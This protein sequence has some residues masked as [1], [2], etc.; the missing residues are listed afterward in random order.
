M[1]PRSINLTNMARIKRSNRASLSPIDTAPH[2]PNSARKKPKPCLMSADEA[3]CSK[4]CS[5]SYTD[6][7]RVDV[8]V[9]GASRAMENPIMTSTHGIFCL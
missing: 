6:P 9:L 4:G 1:D 5:L 3:T 8:T 7:N 2:R